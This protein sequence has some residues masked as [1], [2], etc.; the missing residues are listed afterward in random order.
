MKQLVI[1]RIDGTFAICVDTDQKYFAI[2]IAE[3]PAGAAPGSVLAIT[4]EGELRLEP[5]KKEDR[6]GKKKR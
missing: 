5:S 3:L 6:K 2:E 4:E 1:D